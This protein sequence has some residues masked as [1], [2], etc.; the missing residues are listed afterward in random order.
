MMLAEIYLEEGKL[1]EAESLLTQ[2]IQAFR[3]TLGPGHPRTLQAETSLGRVYNSRNDLSRAEQVWQRALEGFRRLSPN[4]AGCGTSDVCELLGW[5]LSQQ[6]KYE[7]SE[8]LLRQAL[9][10]REAKDRDA[11]QFFWAQALL[12]ASLA[13]EGKYAD[14]ETL[15]LSG[16]EGLNKRET[17]IPAFQKRWIPLSGDQIVTLY[18]LWSKPEQAAR[19]RARLQAQ[20]AR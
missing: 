5:N 4:T 11:W 16:Y 15:L 14:A 7:Q 19:W 17:A 8:S 3:D 6:H 9:A 10:A 1:A 2:A 12:G 20:P 18:S 13:G